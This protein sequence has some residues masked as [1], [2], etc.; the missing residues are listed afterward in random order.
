MTIKKYLIAAVAAASVSAAPLA[1]QQFSIPTDAS[2]Q[3]GGGGSFSSAIAN[4]VT[5]AL[6]GAG[7]TVFNPATGGSMDVPTDVAAAVSAIL[8]GGTDPQDVA[9]AVAAFGGT[10]AAGGLVRALQALGT[11]GGMSAT[12]AS[13][14]VNAYNAAVDAL[15]AGQTPGPGLLLAR[16]SL[17]AFTT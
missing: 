9:A 2:S 1:A 10:P 7:R 6:M 14:A 17:A 3:N 11:A 5:V 16:A 4:Y 13:N 12:N 8:K 15:P